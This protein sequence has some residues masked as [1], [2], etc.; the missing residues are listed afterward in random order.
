MTD[1]PARLFVAACGA[2]LSDQQSWH[3]LRTAAV[4]WDAERDWLIA[5]CFDCSPVLPQ[6]FARE[7][8]PEAMSDDVDLSHPCVLEHRVDKGP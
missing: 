6:P 7:R 3:E 2:D 5:V 8:D 1:G 4:T